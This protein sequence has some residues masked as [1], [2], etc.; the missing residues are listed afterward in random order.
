MAHLA[1]AAERAFVDNA[2]AIV[3]HTVTGFGAWENLVVAIAPSVVRT[4]FG[5]PDAHAHVYCAGRA[6]VAT[7]YRAV[8]ADEL[9]A[10]DAVPEGTVRTDARTVDAGLAT[11]ARTT[12]AT[13]SIIATN[14]PRAIRSAPKNTT[15]A[16]AGL[17]KRTISVVP[18]RNAGARDA[19]RRGTRTSSAAGAAVVGVILS[20]DAGAVAA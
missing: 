15:A 1:N 8:A 13:A 9:L 6:A 11:N 12:T 16:L 18:A 4:Q 2:I 7:L 17:A 3:I 19:P 5:A 14:G 20:I 10:L